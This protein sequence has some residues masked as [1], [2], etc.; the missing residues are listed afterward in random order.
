MT[1]TNKESVEVLISDEIHEAITALADFF[2]ITYRE[3][4]TNAL[5]V[6]IDGGFAAAEEI[7]SHQRG[8]ANVAPSMRIVQ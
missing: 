5:V 1:S 4:F 2:G 6:G 8:R 3:A 7:M